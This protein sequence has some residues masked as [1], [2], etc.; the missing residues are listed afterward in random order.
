MASRPLPEGERGTP[1]WPR[2]DKER[3]SRRPGGPIYRER[4]GRPEPVSAGGHG[5][6]AGSRAT[7]S[8]RS[9][10]PGGVARR[11][12]ALAGGWRSGCRASGAHRP[13]RGIGAM[14][15]ELGF[16][17]RLRPAAALRHQRLAVPEGVG[18]GAVGEAGQIDHAIDVAAAV[19]MIEQARLGAAA[20]VQASASRERPAAA[21]GAAYGEIE[22]VAKPHAQGAIGAGAGERRHPRR[23]R[24]AAEW[25]RRGPHVERSVR[26]EARIGIG[27][28]AG[29]AVEARRR[30]AVAE[31]R[32]Q[33][34]LRQHRLRRPSQ[35]T[36]EHRNGNTPRHTQHPTPPACATGRRLQPAR[37]RTP[38]RELCAHRCQFSLEW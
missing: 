11:D 10:T 4:D 29:I 20:G 15:L 33:E 36:C 27:P 1:R 5:C 25:A 12:A 18:Q 32:L 7:G 13:A 8:G 28:R 17:P 31:E 34:A 26:R 3:Y 6:D 30:R 16:R 9:T 24:A 38:W 22:A 2:R 35:H 23:A 14:A 37:T 21:G 19:G